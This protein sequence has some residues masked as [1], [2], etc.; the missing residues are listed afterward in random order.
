MPSLNLFTPDGNQLTIYDDVHHGAPGGALSPWVSSIQRL[1]DIMSVPQV[2]VRF[3]QDILHVKAE[4]PDAV[5]IP[6]PVSER[7]PSESEI[8]VLFHELGHL[9]CYY[10]QLPVILEM[11]TPWSIDWDRV[12]QDGIARTSPRYQS[13]I[14]R[15]LEVVSETLA[16]LFAL[17]YKES[18]D[19]FHAWIEEQVRYRERAP[20]DCYN[21]FIKEA[22]DARL[23]L[24][25]SRNGLSLPKSTAELGT[26]ARSLV[27]ALSRL[28]V[29]ISRDSLLGV[30]KDVYVLFVRSLRQALHSTGP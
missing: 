16:D 24:L 18:H 26:I 15:M 17:H 25:C 19:A 3:R 7:E 8:Y 29:D 2:R 27:T 30:F 10:R 12:A 28:T 21:A 20:P 23:Y 4:P 11:G 22:G 5:L 9:K 1:M 13:V 14:P 6:K